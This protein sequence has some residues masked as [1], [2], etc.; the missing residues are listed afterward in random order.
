MFEQVELKLSELYVGNLSRRLSI[1]QTNL[2]DLEDSVRF[3]GKILKPLMVR[4]SIGGNFEIVKGCRRFIV[5][6]KL[7]Y[8]SLPCLILPEFMDD[9]KCL[10]IS[11][12][13]NASE[14]TNPIEDALTF[15]TLYD[16]HKLSQMDIALAAGLGKNGRLIVNRYLS[17]LRLSK[18]VQDLV[19]SNEL[20]YTFGLLLLDVAEPKAQYDLAL[21]ALENK[22]THKQ[23]ENH[24]S[25]KELL[26][27]TSTIA[28][29]DNRYEKASNALAEIFELNVKMKEGK[30]GKVDIT[31]SCETP[32]DLESFLD[33]VNSL[34]K[35]RNLSNGS[36]NN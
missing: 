11:L 36:T 19:A 5:A 16:E 13:L 26:E 12:T 20:P 25:N 1:E 27:R 14:K 18:P 8:D 28:S 30:G 9:S 4:R 15:R 2:D 24:I 10:L 21:K 34:A 3:H 7:G 31:F 17:L 22:W 6:N 23:L 35:N 32:E 33:A 29:P